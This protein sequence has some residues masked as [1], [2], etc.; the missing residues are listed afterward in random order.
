MKKNNLTILNDGIDLVEIFK[1]LWKNKILILLISGACL[2]LAYLFKTTISKEFKT[3]ITIKNPSLDFFY[4][5]DQILLKGI[6]NNN[7]SNSLLGIF[8]DN[9]YLN[10]LSL[11]NLD[12]F[13]DQ[14][15]EIDN[16]KLFLKKNNLSAKQ[17]FFSSRFGNLK[18]RNVKIPNKIY[19]IFPKELDGSL[20]LTNY[21]NFIKN[22]TEVEFINTLNHMLKTLIIQKKNLLDDE[23]SLNYFSDVENIEYKIKEISYY[24]KLLTKLEINRFV[25][26]PIIDKSPNQDISTPIVFYELAGLIIGLFLSL[27]I[28]Y[29]KKILNKK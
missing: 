26:N 23:K 10:L 19:L 13:I 18:E 4:E 2:I 25:Y 12:N 1:T 29:L 24:E 8:V 14:N 28:I 9:F 16:F 21:I 3:Y 17:Y 5:Y 20:F 22:K 15:K 7:L 6:K 27:V 11:D